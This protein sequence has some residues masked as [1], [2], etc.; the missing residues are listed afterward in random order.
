MALKLV[1]FK[2]LPG[3]LAAVA[4]AL[5]DPR[6]DVGVIT[7]G[8]HAGTDA[9]ALADE[10]ITEVRF[11]LG[12]G[13]TRTWAE[14]LGDRDFALAWEVVAEH[15]LLEAAKLPALAGAVLVEGEYP[16]PAKPTAPAPTP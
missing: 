10:P 12:E 16:L 2:K 4:G 14:M 1:G 15:L 7:L 13:G 3:A 5:L 11:R 6:Q 9:S 8:V